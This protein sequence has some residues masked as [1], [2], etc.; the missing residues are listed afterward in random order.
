MNVDKMTHVSNGWL[1]YGS[2][3]C[4][5]VFKIFN[6]MLSFLRILIELPSVYPPGF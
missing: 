6:T 1:I 3:S 5:T 2:I 4:Y